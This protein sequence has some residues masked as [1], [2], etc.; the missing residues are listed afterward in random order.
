V[1]SAAPPFQKPLELTDRRSAQALFGLGVASFAAEQA[2]AGYY[3]LAHHGSMGF[4]SAV[5]VARLGSYLLLFLGM[6]MLP[7]QPLPAPSRTRQ[8]V[9]SL[10]TI[11]AVA[12]LGWYFTLGPEFLR[13]DQ[14]I[15][16]E[17]VR[18]GYSVLDLVLIFGLTLLSPHFREVSLQR[19]LLLLATALGI[20]VASDSIRDYQVLHGLP[21][22]GPLLD[23]ARITGFLL[24]GLA[25]AFPRP[26]QRAQDSTTA[27]ATLVGPAPD[28]LIP[29]VWRYIL[30]Y[31]LIP[32]VVTLM[33][34]VTRTPADTRLTSGV[35]IGG[36][37]LIE[38]VF[39][40]QFLAYRELIAYSHKSAHLES[41]ASA[42]PITGLPNHRT[43][44]ARLDEEL[45]RSHRSSHACAILVLDLDRFKQL[46]D[47]YGH[48][49]GDAALREFASVVRM[50][51]RSSDVL[52]RWG[53][54][55]FVAILPET[56]WALALAVSERIRAAVSV[57]TFRTIAGGHVTCSIGVASY[58]LQTLDRDS[59]IELADQA[60]YVAKRL[61]RDQVHMLDHPVETPESIKTS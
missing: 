35:Y 33:I 42:D 13:T 47:T 39:V 17:I 56:D 37:I 8:L 34:Y 27:Q 58:P 46:N 26:T 12:T 32:A 24:V 3:R 29:T 44:V 21:G 49:A 23:V 20:I 19:F 16:A 61:G 51:L 15:F 60:M 10:M 31:T 6:L 2:V 48:R 38:L 5:D 53:G 14:T 36:A 43:V 57:H 50:V 22:T 55:E 40:H 18:T 45:E 1:G 59:L 11:A 30:P 25:A 28:P 54:E 52:G 4:P 9:N 41:L 7:R